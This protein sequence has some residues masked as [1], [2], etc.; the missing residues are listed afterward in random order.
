MTR[1]KCRLMFLYSLLTAI[2]IS[3]NIQAEP[4]EGVGFNIIADEFVD[5]MY[6]A[7]GDFDLDNKIDLV[8]SGWADGGYIAYG[9]GAGKFE[10]P[11]A[12]GIPNH[13]SLALD[14]VN[15]DTLLDIIA[16]ADGVIYV[17]L[18]NGDRTFTT[19]SWTHIASSLSFVKTGYFNNDTYLDFVTSP[20]TIFYG[21]G[22]G[23]F[24]SSDTLPTGTLYG[25][26]MSDFN[27]D[28]Y[29]DLVVLEDR[30]GTSTSWIL[31]NDGTGS[32]SVSDSLVLGALSISVSTSNS[33]ADFN[34]DGNPDFVLISPLIG[35]TCSSG[36]FLSLGTIALGDGNGGILAT[37]NFEVCGTS[38]NMTTADVNR[39]H[40]LDIVVANGSF[41]RLE[42]LLGNGDGTFQPPT[43]VPLGANFITFV[44]AQ[45]DYNRDGNPDFSS[46]GGLFVKDSIYSALNKQPVRPVIND[47]MVTTGYSSVSFDITNPDGFKISR[48]KNTVAGGR[49]ERLDKDNDG[50]LD[51][52]A[53]DYNLE[54]GDYTLVFR[55]RDDITSPATF[56]ADIRIGESKNLKIFKDYDTPGTTKG[57]AA[58]DSIVFKI[59]INELAQTVPE[60]GE[61]EFDNTPRF[62]W[63]GLALTGF[64]SDIS[65]DFQLDSKVDF[66]SPLIS[67]T[68][69]DNHVYS[70]STPLTRDVIY[71]WRV[72]SFDG[73]NY[74]DWS[75]AMAVY[76]GPFFCGDINDDDN[77]PNILDLV[78]MVDFNFRGGDPYLFPVYADLN[79]DGDSG[80]ILDITFLVDYMHRGGSRPSCGI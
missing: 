72:R 6:L 9:E 55:R 21:D 7:A 42:V 40:E 44:L 36:F 67:E 64:G 17:S 35:T 4:N 70:V 69:L 73:A 33:L 11:A 26:D 19:S 37:E 60:S 22:T 78:Y 58:N 27:K 59:S 79:G 30:G 62:S 39:D 32:F 16:N 41:K 8:F 25:A 56:D 14:Y 13:S 80:N 50:Q 10:N 3:A 52:Q 31:L 75:N 61:S 12:I 74:S 20:S 18:N 76:I 66:L 43:R 48:L 49:Y 45:G 34:N 46:G 2:L 28:G 5:M 38:Y 29:D 68:G 51:A 23:A 57:S 47:E 54:Y 63:G 77:G 1:A 71:Y 24:N 53:Y 15:E 65:Y